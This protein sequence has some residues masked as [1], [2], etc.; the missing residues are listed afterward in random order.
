M[1]QF[2]LVSLFSILLADIMLGLG[3]SLGP[4]LSLKNAMLYVIFTA[5]VLEFVLGNR[6]LLREIWPLHLSWAVLVTYATFTWLAIILLGLHR[7]YNPVSNF[8]ALK[9]QLLDLFLFFLVYLYGPKDALKS[10]NL[11]RWLI[12][13]LVLVNVI[14]F[15]DVFNIPDLGIISDRA[16]GRVTGPVNEVNQYGAI[17]VFI[18]PISAGLA[19]SSS[20]WLRLLFALGTVMGFVLLGMTVSR[21]AY[22]G[23]IVGGLFS[24]FLLR[25]YVRK[26]FIVKGSVAILVVV[27]LAVV[28]VAVQNPEAF[29]AKFD[30]TGMSLNRVS[31]GRLLR[32]RQ[33]FTM[34]S[35]WPFSFVVGFGWNAYATLFVVF[36]D[37]HNTYLGY[38]FDLGIIGLS[39]Y[40]FIVIWIIRYISSSLKQISKGVRPIVIG[41]VIG[42]IALHVALFFVKLYTPWLFVWA[43]T[44]TLLRIIADD[45]RNA[46]SDTVEGKIEE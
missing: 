40:L 8:I 27:A 43:L 20:G 7:G 39:L 36:G 30:T 2:L 37:S 35:Y 3:L 46:L 17:L 32:W 10:L 12:T 28:I 22:V 44:G 23:I 38:W 33:I 41:F 31:S 25:D 5:L 24:L 6:D 26:E 19:I 14:T 11:I 29:L 15:I 13:V 45:R 34:M 4:G 9:G 16:D 42:F 18:I 1:R 21:G